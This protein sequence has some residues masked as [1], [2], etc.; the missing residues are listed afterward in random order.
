MSATIRQQMV[1]LLEQA[2]MDLE[3]LSLALG[4]HEKETLAH[5]PHVVKSL[6]ARGV[7]LRTEP[8]VCAACG[9]VFKDRRR[10]SPPSR[11]PRCKQ[12]RI[13]GPWYH[14]PVGD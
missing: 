13:R 14:I 10:L 1:Q 12:S 6:A 4:I 8:A 5:L 2:A 7:R 3:Q 9:F 11:C